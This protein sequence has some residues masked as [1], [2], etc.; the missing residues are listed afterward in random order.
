MPM[1]FETS[2]QARMLMPLVISIGFGIL[3]AAL[4]TLISS[5]ICNKYIFKKKNN[6]VKD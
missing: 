6:T 3:F 1:I 2:R 4:I 5:F